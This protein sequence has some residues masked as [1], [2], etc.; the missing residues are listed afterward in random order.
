MQQSHPVTPIVVS[1]PTRVSALARLAN[2][3]V[4]PRA[5]F[6]DVGM[7]PT[8]AAAFAALIALRFASL[9]AFYRPDTNPGKLVVGVLFQ[10]VTVGPLL[11]LLSLV[12]WLVGVLWRARM[13]WATA[14]SIAVHV[15]FAYT[16]ATVLVAS[17]A[18]ALL[19]ASVEVDLRSPPFTNLEFLAGSDGNPAV[20][21][22]LALVDVRTAY[23]LVLVSIGVG[24]ARRAGISSR[25]S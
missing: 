3:V 24:A 23:A 25:A 18:G 10:I 22:L 5:A 1:A 15:L 13:S 21:R 20:R 2:V 17:V 7:A 6:R 12:L 14:V 11:F 19:P 4:D 8:W 16:L 9:F